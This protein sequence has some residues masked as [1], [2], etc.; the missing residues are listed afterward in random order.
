MCWRG[1][2]IIASSSEPHYI[3][4]VKPIMQFPAALHAGYMGNSLPMSAECAWQ[5]WLEPLSAR[6]WAFGMV[7]FT[8][9]GSRRRWYRVRHD[10]V[11]KRYG[12]ATDS[13]GFADGGSRYIRWK[14]YSNVDLWTEVSGR[15]GDEGR[16]GADIRRPS[17]EL[18][19]ISQ[20]DATS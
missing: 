15:K 12:N 17:V 9:I 11:G 2:F 5:L 6:F 16:W 3:E 7:L 13:D 19:T 10:C 18:R 20:S 4:F 14:I 1:S 8:V